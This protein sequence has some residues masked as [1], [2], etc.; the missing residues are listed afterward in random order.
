MKTILLIISLFISSISFSHIQINDD[1]NI[2]NVITQEY[3]IISYKQTDEGISIKYL[4]KSDYIN[5]ILIKLSMTKDHKL[6]TP[7]YISDIKLLIKG[8]HEIIIP[9]FNIKEY[10]CKFDCTFIIKLNNNDTTYIYG[11]RDNKYSPIIP[12]EI[13]EIIIPI[14]YYNIGVQFNENN[15]NK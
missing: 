7:Y 6:I 1:Y 2:P 3:D 10:P 9:A 11:L 13:E 5:E 4:I 14:E 15:L 12:K 8:Y